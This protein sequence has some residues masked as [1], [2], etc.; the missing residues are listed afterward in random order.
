MNMWH[1]RTMKQGETVLTALCYVQGQVHIV[2]CLWEIV[3][4]C[5]CHF[6][7]LRSVGTV[8]GLRLQEKVDVAKDEARN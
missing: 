4:K 8:M 7:S 1:D 5:C 2:T 3:S 6:S